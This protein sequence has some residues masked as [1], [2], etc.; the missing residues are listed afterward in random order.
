MEYLDGGTL[1]QLIPPRGMRLGEALK[2]AVQIADALA[3][4]HGAGIIHRDI[5]PANIMVNP[6]HIRSL[7]RV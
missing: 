7:R 6:I 1:E 2:H 4:A 5:K 3:T